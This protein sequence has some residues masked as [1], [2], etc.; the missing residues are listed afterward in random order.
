MKL[1]N[2]SMVDLDKLL[3]V[4]ILANIDNIIIENGQVSGV[5]E[6]RSC[7]IISDQN[8]PS[9]G[10]DV[11]LGIS[12]LSTL[13]TRMNLFKEDPKV[14]IEAKENARKEISQ[15]EISGTNAKVQF[16]CSSPAMIKAP[17]AITANPLKDVTV[18][19][20][21][22]PIILSGVRAMGSKRV[23]LAI[24]ENGETTLDFSDTNNDAFNVTLESK[25][26]HL[27]EDKPASCVHYYPAEIMLPLIRAGQD[28]SSISIIVSDNGV[29][30][31]LVNG[32]IM[33]MLP[34]IA[35]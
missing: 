24:K 26:N 27:G 20:S 17:K 23:T 28:Q 25:A 29:A 16:R 32:H 35:D 12:R 10:T 11:K 31:L 4:C 34:Q 13:Q 2:T 21:E 18:L 33:T 15:L 3:S 6:E 1:T 5:N 9:F 22:I 7:A 19:K 14:A 30:Q 8:I